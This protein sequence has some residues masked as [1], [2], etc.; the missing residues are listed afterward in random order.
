MTRKT[1]QLVLA[2]IAMVLAA[3]LVLFFT[4]RR[5]VKDPIP[6]QD[7]VV[8]MAAWLARHPTD[9]LTASQ[10]SDAALDSNLPRREELWR[11]SYALARHIA[12]NL[13]NPSAAFVRGG[14][15]HWYELG[16]ADRK[17]VLDATAPLLR[18]PEFFTEMHRSLWQ[19]TR[20]F[21]YLFR[22]APPSLGALEDL[23]IM[24]ASNGL[25]AEYRQTRDAV[26]R[27]RLA[28]FARTHASL[29]PHELPSLL[30]RR[31]STD[32]EPLIVRILQE[33]HRRSYEPARF[34]DPT[35]VMIDY[36]IAHHLQP[37]EGLAPFV[38]AVKVIPDATRARLARALGRHDDAALIELSSVNAPAEPIP[39]AR[40]E[41]RGT[42]GANELCD[43]AR[44]DLHWKGGTLEIEADT[45]QSDQIAPYVEIYADDARVAEGEVAQARRFEV[46][47]APGVHRIEV[48]LVNPRIANNVQRRVRLS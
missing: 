23:R 22:N 21:D 16:D 30:P 6:P 29:P 36:A 40:P 48:R 18:D 41:W 11:A 25:F 14:L 24:A 37:L 19:L 27:E 15:F 33:L 20:D 35:T 46:A 1:R 9:W 43:L 38:D 2:S 17:A 32:D 39:S 8:P 47:L 26:A 5:V 44:T 45:V 34:G 7:D 10:L 12:P 42:C 28:T 31:L 4:N 13:Q 3:V